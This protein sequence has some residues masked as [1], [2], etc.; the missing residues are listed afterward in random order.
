MSQQ[1]IDKS[2]RFLGG[3]TRVEQSA[4]IEFPRGPRI[5]F[6]GRSNVGKSSLLNALVKS[7]VARVSQEPGR[8]REINFFFWNGLILADL[9]GYGFAKVSRDLRQEWG[10]EIP[11]FLTTPPGIDLIVS[12]IDGRHGFSDQDQEL[13]KFLQAK[14]LPFVVAFTKMD[15]YKSSNQLRNGQRLLEN[16]AKALFVE[17]FVFCSVEKAGG[18]TELKTLLM[19]TKHL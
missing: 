4:N 18:V 16:Q 10:A 15:K 5:A 14:S 1:K 17:R 2:A 13:I 6:A 3:I 9:P 11:R 8:T 12:L 7:R 19:R